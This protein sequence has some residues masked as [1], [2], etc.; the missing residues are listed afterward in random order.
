MSTLETERELVY[1]GYPIEVRKHP[2][3]FRCGYVKLDI[4]H[5]LYGVDYQ[6]EKF[7]YI[8][9][10]GGVTYSAMEGNHW[11]LGFDTGHA[12]DGF[13]PAIMDDEYRQQM[14]KM[15]YYQVMLKDG[16]CWS[17]ADIIEELCKM[18]D[19]LEMIRL[20]SVF[21]KK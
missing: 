1:K 15:S 5:P 8:P 2:V 9:V 4:H 19:C 12:G 18:V 21:G 16:V 3:G 20:K 13:D 17:T 14:E 10:H 6:D 11:V 7:P